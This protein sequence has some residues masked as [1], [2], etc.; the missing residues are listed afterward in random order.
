M[1]EIIIGRFLLVLLR[2]QGNGSCFRQGEG[3]RQGCLR[4]EGGIVK[5]GGGS[6]NRIG[7]GATFSFFSWHDESNKLIKMALNTI[8]LYFLK[9]M[10]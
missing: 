7:Y 4:S 8:K 10:I 6:Y 1:G 9:F 3:G 2:Y 5:C